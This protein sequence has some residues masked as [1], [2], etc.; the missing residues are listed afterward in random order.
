MK[1]LDEMPEARV[2]YTRYVAALAD[3]ATQVFM[4]MAG[5]RVLNHWVDQMD[6][7]EE[8]VPVAQTIEYRHLNRPVHGNFILGFPKESMAVRVA[9]AV[10]ARMGMPEVETLD[11]AALDILNEFMNTIV[12]RTISAWDRM[13]LPVSFTTPASCQVSCF[14]PNQATLKAAYVVKL[15][16]TFTDILLRVSFHEEDDSPKKTIMVVED[17]ALIRSVVAR[18]LRQMGHQVEEADDGAKALA[19]FRDVRPDLTIMDLV[20]P[21]MGGLEAM[22]E[23]RNLDPAAKFIVLT[24]SARTDEVVTAKTLGVSRYLI[25]PVNAATL[26]EVVG[27]AL[28]EP[29]ARG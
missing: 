3:Q 18:T 5:V 17:S 26:A 1:T 13:D 23:I 29:P 12:G 10:A 8:N 27:K 11:E 14:R 24:S 22:I 25:K 28:E 16:L 4:D 20:M 2:Q 19:L 21:R 9:S 6:I 7:R 15:A